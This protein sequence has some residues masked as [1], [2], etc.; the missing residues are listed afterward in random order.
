[1][2]MQSTIPV[3]LMIASA[4]IA[5]LVAFYTWQWRNTPGGYYFIL[6]LAAVAIYAFACAFEEAATTLPVKIT[7]SKIS[8]LGVVN[9]SPLWLMFALQFSQRTSWL[10]RRRIAA[11]WIVPF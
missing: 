9:I 4:V 8:Y 6:L 7:W 1:M 5:L 2:D 11:L 3:I 10:T